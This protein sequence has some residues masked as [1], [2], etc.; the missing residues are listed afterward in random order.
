MKVLAK[1]GSYT[2][3][4]DPV[5]VNRYMVYCTY[6]TSPSGDIKLN[7]MICQSSAF[8]PKIKSYFTLQQVNTAIAKVH[9]MKYVSH[10]FK[11]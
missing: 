1:N 11:A 7:Q 8:T 10:K 5:R 3:C 4:Y 2:L 9:A 6:P